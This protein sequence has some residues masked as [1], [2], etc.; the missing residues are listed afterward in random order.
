MTDHEKPETIVVV[1]KKIPSDVFGGGMST[2]RKKKRS[3]T[4]SSI[5]IFS[6]S[7]ELYDSPR[8]EIG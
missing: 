7:G 3:R 1:E 8:E 6:N 5:S 4:G 2:K